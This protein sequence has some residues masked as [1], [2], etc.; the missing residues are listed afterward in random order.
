[1]KEELYRKKSMEKIKSPE[2]LDDYIRVPKPGR[3]M[4]AAGAVILLAGA[5]VWLLF[6]HMVTVP[7]TVY[8]DGETAVCYVA[9]GD[10]SSVESGLTVL[11]SDTEAVIVNV[12]DRSP[13]GYICTLSPEDAVPDGFY[14]GEI[15]LNIFRPLS[16]IANRSD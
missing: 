13:M 5:F 16:F 15:E 6:G 12:G 11:Y 3:W 8:S 7:A 2:A 4:P 9:E 1:M 10:I 14:E